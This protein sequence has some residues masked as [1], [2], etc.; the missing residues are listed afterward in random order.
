MALLPFVIRANIDFPYRDFCFH[1]WGSQL[2]TASHGSKIDSALVHDNVDACSH[3]SHTLIGLSSMC[4]NSQL[5]TPQCI[6]LNVFQVSNPVQNNG[7]LLCILDIETTLQLEGQDLL[8]Q[9]MQAISDTLYR[10]EA[11]L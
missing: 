7:C 3:Q 5:A 11:T 8:V 10:N 4:C 9:V 2:A 6:M 1:N